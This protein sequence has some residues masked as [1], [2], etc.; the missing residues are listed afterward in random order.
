MVWKT[1]KS[2]NTEHTPALY[3]DLSDLADVHGI[4]FVVA[5]IGTT[6]RKLGGLKQMKL[7]GLWW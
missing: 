5:P 4:V 2:C 3:L 7:P 6:I 1:T